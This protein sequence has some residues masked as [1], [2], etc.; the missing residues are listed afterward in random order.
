MRLDRLYL[1]SG[2]HLLHAGDDDAIAVVEAAFD[3][4]LVAARACAPLPVLVE[5]ALPLIRIG[6][7]LVAWKGAVPLDE[8]RAGRSLRDVFDSFGVL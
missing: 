6:G 5:Y 8:L 2:F 7:A 4:P 1:R 3:D